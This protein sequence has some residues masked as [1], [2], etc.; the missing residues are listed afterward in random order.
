[1]IQ[2]Q[3]ADRSAGLES[4]IVRMSTYCFSHHKRRSTGWG[5]EVL[6]FAAMRRSRLVDLLYHM[7][8]SAFTKVHWS[9]YI[10]KTVAQY[11]ASSLPGIASRNEAPAFV[12]CPF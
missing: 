11:H 7:Q 4:G 2:S 6:P 12:L 3:S 1:M 9:V 8:E 5:T 10:S